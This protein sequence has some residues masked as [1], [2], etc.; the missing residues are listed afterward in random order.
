MGKQEHENNDGEKRN[1]NAPTFTVASITHW[2]TVSGKIEH[3]FSPAASPTANRNEVL[4]QRVP[5]E[6]TKGV[7]GGIEKNRFSGAGVFY[8]RKFENSKN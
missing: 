1:T 8:E 2:G 3:S 4:P 6:N 7:C 5:S